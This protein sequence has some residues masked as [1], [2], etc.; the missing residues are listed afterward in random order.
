MKTIK[1]DNVISN[2]V[3]SKRAHAADPPTWAR[4][5]Q[6]GESLKRATMIGF[7]RRAAPFSARI[8]FGFTIT[9]ASSAR[10]ALR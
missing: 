4:S 7:T 2:A 6:R 9:F 8:R 10:I 5:L 3:I 1:C